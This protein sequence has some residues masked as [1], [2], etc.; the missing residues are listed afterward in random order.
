MKKPVKRAKSYDTIKPLIELCKG[1][2]L[3]EIQEWIKAGKPI[4]PPA[5][6][7]K[8]A[9]RKPPLQYAISTGFHSLVQVLLEAGVEIEDSYKYNPVDHAL[10]D[11]R[12]D[13]VKLLIEHGAE[14]KSVNIISVFEHWNP[15]IAEY[16]ISLGADVESDSPLAHA[17]CRRIRTS[18]G[19]FKRYK[20]RF[21]SFQEQLNIALRA[22]CLKGDI[23]WVSLCLWAGADPHKPGSSDPYH[24]QDE[25]GRSAVE[26]AALC[27]HLDVLKMKAMKVGPE[28]PGIANAFNYNYRPNSDEIISYLLERDI[29]PNN[30]ANG[31]C[32]AIQRLLESLRYSASTN[33]ETQKY[34]DTQKTREA[35]KIVHILARGGGK[36]IPHGKNQCNWLRR[37]LLRLSPEYTAEFVWIM[38]KYQACSKQDLQKL[39]GTPTMRTHILQLLPR[40]NVLMSRMEQLEK[41]PA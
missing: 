24:D 35:M 9:R 8:E 20:D 29:N 16:F 2:R 19:I 38:S 18:L 6:K 21:P 22:H 33:D 17:L 3:F 26:C 12:L 25:F 27:G 34:L 30:Q 23:K 41:P 10:E 28:C 36:W 40:I 32:E 39:I 31:G 11:D 14:P 1:G 13:I 7:P 5:P 4:N 37:S 15:A